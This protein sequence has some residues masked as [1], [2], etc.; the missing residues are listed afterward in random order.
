M[1]IHI[2]GPLYLS[3]VVAQFPLLSRFPC[4]LG[5]NLEVLEVLKEQF[6]LICHCIELPTCQNP[7]MSG[8]MNNLFCFKVNERINAS[9]KSNG[10]L[11]NKLNVFP[12]GEI[13]EA[14]K[15]EKYQ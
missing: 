10:N 9:H 3:S 15:E 12:E 2:S 11:N 13:M 8:V 4:S 7:M 5:F 1:R 14:R 6:V